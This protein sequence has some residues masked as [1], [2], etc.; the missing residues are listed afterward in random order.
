MSEDAPSELRRVRMAGAPHDIGHA[1]GRAGRDAVHDVL[2]PLDYWVAVNSP[3]HDHVVA[4]MALRTKALFPWIFEE[5]QGLADGLGLPFAQVMAWNCRGDLMSNV[6]DGCTTLQ[7][8]GDVPVIAHNEDGLPDFRGHV[9]LVDAAPLDAPDFTALCYPGSIPG[10]TFSVTGA[11]LVQA[12][13]NLRLR[14]VRPQIP[15]MVLG[16]AVLACRSVRAAID[17]LARENN[18]GGFHFTLA[19]AGEGVVHSVEFGGGGM[20]HRQIDTPSA[21]ANHALHLDHA[22]GQ[23]VT[24]SS[25]DR[26]R[27]VTDLI[28]AGARNVLAMLRDT[29]EQGLPV[30][31]CQPDDPD[32]ENTLATAIIHVEKGGLSWKVYDQKSTGPVHA[33]SD[34][35]R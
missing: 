19:Q 34:I 25:A 21:H 22:Q 27:R 33:G 24:Q 17:L 7:F 12:V 9:L 14:D 4:R 16:R 11:G 8:P 15:R 35:A 23:I 2:R 30:H 5:L 32:H 13:N 3:A 29:G 26:Q 31:R 10:H 28:D 1:L 20:V 6:P 18:S